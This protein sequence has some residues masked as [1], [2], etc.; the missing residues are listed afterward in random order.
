[1]LMLG[2]PWMSNVITAIDGDHLVILLSPEDGV[3]AVPV[4]TIKI[5]VK[6]LLHILKLEVEN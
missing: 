4:L 2:L 1:M 3:V 6:R 5:N